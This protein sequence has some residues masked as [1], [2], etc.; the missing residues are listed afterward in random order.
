M[1]LNKKVNRYYSLNQYFKENYNEKIYKVSIDAG[2]SCPNRDGTISTGGCI[3]CSESGSGEFAGNRIK[4]ITEQ[5]NEQ[6]ELISSKF[7][8]GKVIA[9]FQNFTNTYGDI[10]Y[11]NKIYNEAIAHP[12]VLGISIATR[13]DCISDEVLNL[14]DN[15]NNK[16]VLWVELGLQ[17]TNDS[18][19]KTINRG[20]ETKVY[21]DIMKKLSALNIK[22]ITHII[23][24][25]PFS[26]FKD[27]MDTA[28]LAVKCGTWGVKLH[29]LY[30]LKNSKLELL[31]SSKS[32]DL[33]ELDDYVERVISI[34]EILPKDIIIHRL[35][36]DG[37]K[38]SLIGPLWSL[39]KRNVLNSIVKKMTAKNIFQGDKVRI[40]H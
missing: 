8:H 23:I 11:L 29:L 13:P 10:E 21:M 22:I 16:T 4:S 36:G 30:L 37:E 15:L 33:L 24:G 35:T 38:N 39:N 19:A 3:F 27:E 6:L 7:P 31:Y 40:S 26:S 28:S 18:V 34:L 32:F 2:F 25:L 9:Y 20:Y 1:E 14:L 17:T 12:R 5:I